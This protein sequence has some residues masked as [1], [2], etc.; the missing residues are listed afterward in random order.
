[1]RMSKLSAPLVTML[2][3]GG[4]VA[5]VLAQQPTQPRASVPVPQKAS[6]YQVL[7]GD[8]LLGIAGKI[9]YPGVTPAQMALA[10]HASNRAAFVGGNIH[11]LVVG[12]IL[13]VPDRETVVAV[14]A[15]QADRQFRALAAGP[16]TPAQG[17]APPAASRPAAPEERFRQARAFE[18]RG[19][20]RAALD[21]YTQAA[22]AGNGPAQKKLGDIYGSG[23]AV[24]VRDYETS[25]KWYTKARDQGIDIPAP[26]TFPAL[27]P[28]TRRVN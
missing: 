1:M 23:N 13:S 28:G 7:K 10:I 5:G 27:V 2:A 18:R 4:P 11:L 8:T 24:V 26:G 15:V 21:A 3:L 19:N 6:T 12:R 14:G 9:A 20:L 17:V 16:N 25:L 22:E